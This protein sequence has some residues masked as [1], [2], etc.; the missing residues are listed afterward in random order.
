MKKMLNDHSS[1]C[2]NIRN[3]YNLNLQILNNTF[4][5]TL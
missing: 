2:E 1:G 5:T 3:K 4:D